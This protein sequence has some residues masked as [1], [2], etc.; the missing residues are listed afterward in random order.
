MDKFLSELKLQNL[1]RQ[2]CCGVVFFVPLYLFVPC[3]IQWVWQH[4]GLAKDSLKCIA[5]LAFIIGTVIYHLE[6]NLYSYAIQTIYEHAQNKYWGI[7]FWVFG[8]LIPCCWLLDM[9]LTKCL[10]LNTGL[11]GV[12]V[13]IIILM[14]SCIC[15][16]VICRTQTQWEI[17]AHS[18]KYTE[19]DWA[20]ADKMAVWSD[21]IHCIQSCCFAWILGAGIAIRITQECECCA[22]KENISASCVAAIC[23]LLI[24]LGIDWHRYRHVLSLPQTMND[25]TVHRLTYIKM[26]VNYKRKTSIMKALINRLFFR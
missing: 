24:E 18:K 9:D 10:C 22:S 15:G 2:F 1:L 8:L 20:I 25:N 16:C 14:I 3:K 21:F 12:I 26:T 17:E 7:L 5:V 19:K 6:K 13:M 23:L 11:I 4:A